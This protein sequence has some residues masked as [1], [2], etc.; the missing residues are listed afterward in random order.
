MGDLCKMKTVFTMLICIFSL[1]SCTLEPVAPWDRNILAQTEMQPDASAID[2]GFDDHIYFSKESSSG[3]GK[4][5]G[6][7][8][9]C[10]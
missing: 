4:L 10:N 6:G 8:C 7:G 1:A 2:D 9:G 3:G 5:G